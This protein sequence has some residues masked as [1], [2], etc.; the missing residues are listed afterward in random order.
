[1]S[2]DLN[3]TGLYTNEQYSITQ[4]IL[5]SYSKGTILKEDE[6]GGGGGGVGG[7]GAGGGGGG[8]GGGGKKY[9]M[10]RV[11]CQSRRNKL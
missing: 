6:K 10:E 2:P 9:F 8:G 5:I 11:I 3:S 1:M 7:G 4:F